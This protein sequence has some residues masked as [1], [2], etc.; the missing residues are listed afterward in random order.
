MIKKNVSIFTALV[1]SLFFYS[2][3]ANKS[4]KSE[5]SKEE[6][7]EVTQVYIIHPQDSISFKFTAFKTLKKVGVSGTFNEFELTKKSVITKKEDLIGSEFIIYTKSVTTENEVRDGKLKKLFFGKLMSRE[8]AGEITGLS[9]S[10]IA[11]DITM[12]EVKKSFSFPIQTTANSIT[13]NGTINMISDFSASE[14]FKSIHE[15]C[16]DLH[17]GKTWEEVDV[18]ATV[19]F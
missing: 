9:D 8:I 6:Q 13:F 15:A 18:E 1:I 16:Y 17:E 19:K 3:D 2:C 4:A 14:A 11:V 12:N 10:N 5:E 7:N